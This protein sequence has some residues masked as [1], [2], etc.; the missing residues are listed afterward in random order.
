MR[1]AKW[2]M[3]VVI[4]QRNVNASSTPFAIGGELV[5]SITSVAIQK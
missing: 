5:C 3:S 1:S 4:T 2:Q